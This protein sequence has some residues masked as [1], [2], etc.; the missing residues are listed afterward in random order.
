MGASRLDVLDGAGLLVGVPKLVVDRLVAD[1]AGEVVGLPIGAD[2]VECVLG[3]PAGPVGDL[4]H[5]RV[6]R[7]RSQVGQMSTP[8]RWTMGF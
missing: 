8:R 6:R 2:L 5:G 3:S 7:M 4:G 1:A